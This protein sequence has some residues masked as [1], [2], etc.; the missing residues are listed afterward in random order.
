MPARA[1]G[2]NAQLPLSVLQFSYIA[3][4]YNRTLYLDT[5]HNFIFIHIGSMEGLGVLG[6]P[7]IKKGSGA[8]TKFF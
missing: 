1:F 8:P 2:T 6:H 3:T 4:F 5:G 7:N